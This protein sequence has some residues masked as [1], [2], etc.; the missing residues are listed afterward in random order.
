MHKY[1]AYITTGEDYAQ[2]E[3]QQSPVVKKPHICMWLVL[4]FS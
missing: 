4:F 3:R 2:M 1:V